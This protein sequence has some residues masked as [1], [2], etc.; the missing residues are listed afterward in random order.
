ML[1]CFYAMSWKRSRRTIFSDIEAGKYTSKN[2]YDEDN[3]TVA[4][5]KS[6]NSGCLDELDSDDNCNEKLSSI[7]YEK[8]SKSERVDQAEVKRDHKF[9]WVNGERVF[10]DNIENKVLLRDP[11]LPITPHSERQGD[12]R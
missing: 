8:A 3:E 9:H 7:T 12:W 10:S 1:Y 11:L 4:I 5:P 2:D 6:D